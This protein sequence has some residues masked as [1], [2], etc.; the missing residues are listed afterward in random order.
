MVSQFLSSGRVDGEWLSPSALEKGIRSEH[1]LKLAVAEMCVPGV[2]ILSVAAMIED[3]C[4]VSISSTQV[5][6]AVAP[7]GE[8]L[9]H[10][11]NPET[12]HRPKQQ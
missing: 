10:W 3:R 1:A 5:S 9:D 2:L 7:P 12:Q 11:R 8:E 4:G 6:G